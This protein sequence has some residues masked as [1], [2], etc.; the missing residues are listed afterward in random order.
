[1]ENSSKYPV[2]VIFTALSGLL[3]FSI[4]IQY[5]FKKWKAWYSQDERQFI[6]SRCKVGNGILLLLWV[7]LLL[8]R[9]GSWIRSSVF[10][11]IAEMMWYVLFVLL[12][13]GV[14]LILSGMSFQLAHVQQTSLQKKQML[15]SFLPFYTDWLWFSSKQFDKPYWWNKE[16]Q[17]WWLI[18]VLILFFSSSVLFVEVFIL[19]LVLRLT[20]LVCGYDVI[21]Q[22][23]KV[24][25]HHLFKVYP[26]ESISLL[27]VQIR[28]FFNPNLDNSLLVRYQKS[29][30]LYSTGKEKWMSFV[31]YLIAF[32]FLGVW[33]WYEWLWWKSSVFLWFLVRFFI[34][35]KNNIPIPKPPVIAEFTI[36][37]SHWSDF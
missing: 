14:S 6:L 27:V 37:Q 17:I 30:S 8:M 7:V 26:E 33:M 2:P 16:A 23:Q 4:F 11:L 15:Y 31:V 12:G 36:S 9:L 3:F 29:Y 10:F 19:L 34:L 24:W 32:G 35:K 20:L 28:K 1:M 25:L 18:I 21:S 22:E 5:S 13:I